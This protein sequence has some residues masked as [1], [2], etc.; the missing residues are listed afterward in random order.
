MS[1]CDQ[2]SFEAVFAGYALG[3]IV[4]VTILRDGAERVIEL[5]VRAAP[6]TLV[7]EANDAA[8]DSESAI[9]ES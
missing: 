1:L 6:T 4:K 9:R 3:D 7:L 8:S 2:K 5:E